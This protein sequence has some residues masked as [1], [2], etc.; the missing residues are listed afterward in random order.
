[1]RKEAGVGPLEMALKEIQVL[2]REETERHLTRYILTGDQESLE[3]LMRHYGTLALDKAFR[4]LDRLGHEVMDVYSR[5]MSEIF[6]KLTEARESR[7]WPMSRYNFTF[8]LD[9]QLERALR[10]YFT[11]GVPFGTYRE[12]RM[13]A[14]LRAKRQELAE[15]LGRAP[16]L[17]ELA[18]ALEISASDLEDLLV[19]EEANR[20]L[21]LD[22]PHPETGEEFGEIIPDKAEEDDPALELLEEAISRSRL[23]MDKR[24]VEE[25]D[26]FLNGE[27]ESLDESILGKIKAQMY[28]LLRQ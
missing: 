9:V 17:E 3:A 23:G 2:S 16:T 21:S 10:E 12:R 14:K 22:A 1:M 6:L 4:Y 8:Y 27:V 7:G 11:Q 24:E 20:L 18:E 28:S 26:R 19:L 15:E 25:L 5:L 13:L